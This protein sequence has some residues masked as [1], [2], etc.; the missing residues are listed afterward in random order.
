[1]Q[2]RLVLQCLE[3]SAD[4]YAMF[5]TRDEKLTQQV[6][7]MCANSIVVPEVDILAKYVA[8]LMGKPGVDGSGH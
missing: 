8:S 7:E 3:K 5:V 6:H 4:T 2:L 1:M